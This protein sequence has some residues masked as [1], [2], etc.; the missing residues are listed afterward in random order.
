MI[1]IAQFQDFFFGICGS[2]TARFSAKPT[3]VIVTTRTSQCLQ[4]FGNTYKLAVR[5]FPSPVPDE[6]QSERNKQQRDFVGAALA[7]I[8]DAG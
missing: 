6:Q 7:A 3:A 5:S 4:N 8:P 2:P 1:L